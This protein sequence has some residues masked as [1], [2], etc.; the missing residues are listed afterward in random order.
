MSIN[1]VWAL[2]I[3]SIILLTISLFP[4]IMW[5]TGSFNINESS[6]RYVFLGLSLAGLLGL[7]LLVKSAPSLSTE[8][9]SEPE[10]QIS[11]PIFKRQ[12]TQYTPD[13]LKPNVGTYVALPKY[14]LPPPINIP[15]SDESITPSIPVNLLP[16]PPPSP[17]V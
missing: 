3:V 1:L 15:S 9:K 14:D 11:T 17:P 6:A 16:P 2:I 4:Q 10:I 12:V 13:T 5:A 7:W 8:S